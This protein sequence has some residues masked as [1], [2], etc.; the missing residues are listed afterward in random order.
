MKKINFTNH[1]EFVQAARE[2]FTDDYQLAYKEDSEDG[3][4]CLYRMPDDPNVRCLIGRLFYGHIPEGH[5]FWEYEGSL[6]SATG[7]HD[8]IQETFPWLSLK[9]AEKVQKFHDTRAGL[10]DAKNQDTLSWDALEKEAATYDTP[11]MVKKQQELREK[12]QN[13]PFYYGV[14]SDEARQANQLRHLLRNF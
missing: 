4:T 8:I 9:I 12:V 7:M 3:G 6:I 11:E 14:S 1:V 10:Y 13:L 2:L 5:P